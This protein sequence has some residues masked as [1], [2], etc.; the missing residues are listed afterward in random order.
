[1][2]S[3]ARAGGYAV[4]A[5]NVVDLAT[6]DGVLQAAEASRSPVI[7]QTAAKTARTWGPAVIA[8][9]FRALGT[10]LAVPAVLQLDHTSELA[11]VDAC[12]EAG[13][14]AVLFDGSA[15]PA[16]ENIAQT[17]G[18]VERAHAVGASVEGELVSIRGQEDGVATLA[19][20]SPTTGLDDELAFIE[21]TGIDCFAPSIGNVHGRTA[22]PP[23]IDVDRAR[24]L[25]SATSTPLA[26]HGGTG[27]PADV[28]HAL[29]AAG[30]TKV[31]VS[32]A[33]RE[34]ATAAVRE[35]L[36]TT[37]DDPLPLLLAM[38]DAARAVATSTFELLGR[39]AAP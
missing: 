27:I 11:V 31:N 14:N 8:A 16:T 22:T 29:I 37:G 1:V 17:R 5:F 2:L 33:L 26:L 15:L 35:R 32:T 18:V 6:M 30:C 38:R 36:P 9:I 24:R 23:T 34:A 7:V 4:A 39:E 3:D 13:W 19:E 20:G 28:M 21:G 25:A 10:P 12:L